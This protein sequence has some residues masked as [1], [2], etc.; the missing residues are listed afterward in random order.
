MS[1]PP[2]PRH[3]FKSHGPNGMFENFTALNFD[4]CGMSMRRLRDVSDDAEV[5]ELEK[6]S[7]AKFKWLEKIATDGVVMSSD[8]V[9]ERIFKR[10]DVNNGDDERMLYFTVFWM[11]T[12]AELLWNWRERLLALGISNYAIVIRQHTP[13]Q[14]SKTDILKKLGDQYVGWKDELARWKGWPDYIYTSDDLVQDWPLCHWRLETDKVR[15]GD[16]NSLVKVR[17]A[18]E[19]LLRGISV[20]YCDVD[21]VIFERFPVE[22][23]QEKGMAF[24]FA[25]RNMPDEG[26]DL[27]DACFGQFFMYGGKAQASMMTQLVHDMMTDRG[28]NRSTFCDDQEHFNRMIE[29]NRKRILSS[30]KLLG[31]EASSR[32]FGCKGHNESCMPFRKLDTLSYMNGESFYLSYFL[33]DEDFHK[34]YGPKTIHFTTF[35]TN[36]YRNRVFL[37]RELGLMMDSEKYYTEEKFLIFSEIPYDASKK[38]H[39]KSLKVSLALAKSTGRCLIL[40]RLPCRMAV[41]ETVVDRGGFYQASEWC[42]ALFVY[43]MYA[44]AEGVCVRESTF[45]TKRYWTNIGSSCK[46]CDK[47]PDAS[48]AEYV[49]GVPADFYEWHKALSDKSDSDLLRMC[50]PQ[51]SLDAIW[52]SIKNSTLTALVEKSL[53]DESDVYEQFLR[54]ENRPH[55]GWIPRLP[56]KIIERTVAVHSWPVSVEDQCRTHS[57]NQQFTGAYAVN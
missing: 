19:A 52:N 40:P 37:L 56:P 8:P 15:S 20:Y 35:F 28:C 22:Y 45:L 9:I 43:N 2:K 38:V 54:D 10:A 30:V 17:F 44:L 39:V 12:S 29:L 41:L 21:C 55:T 53:K 46:H 26:C 1:D 27:G 5:T 4:H 18:T 25:G 14:L 36:T 34:S 31:T 48:L 24:A 50:T 33:Q 3:V 32:C 16:T 42:E 23:I 51:S 47:V 49:S 13:N 7:I 6:N 57:F 11:G